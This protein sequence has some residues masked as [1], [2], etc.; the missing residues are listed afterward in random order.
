MSE[1]PVLG[2]AGGGVHLR[3]ADSGLYL[4]ELTASQGNWP[5]TAGGSP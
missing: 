2:R 5:S 1:P 4:S 3:C